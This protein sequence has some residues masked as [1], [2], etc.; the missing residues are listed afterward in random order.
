MN[1]FLLNLGMTLSL[2]C[3]YVGYFFRFKNNRLH[4]IINTIG[5]LCNLAAAVF[6]LSWKYMLGGLEPMGIVAVVPPIVVI[7]HRICASIALILMLAMAFSGMTGKKEI[8]K[9][10]HKIFLILYTVVFISGLF[11][12]Q[13][14]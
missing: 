12:F 6:L 5:V 8:H 1:L 7:I 3:F 14:R 2:L 13:A 10:L 9:K 11:I 4:R